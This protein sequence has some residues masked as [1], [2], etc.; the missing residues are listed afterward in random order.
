MERGSRTLLLVWVL[1]VPTVVATPAVT[2]A[3]AAGMVARTT[4][5]MRRS[6]ARPTGWRHGN[7]AERRDG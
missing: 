5:P 4:C 3:P 1:P 6:D 7:A 2:G